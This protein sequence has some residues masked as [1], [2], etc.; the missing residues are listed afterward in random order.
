MPSALHHLHKRKRVNLKKEKYP[1]KERLKILMDKLIYLVA[2]GGPIIS[3]AQAYEIWFNKTAAGVSLIT[4]GGY[5]LGSFAWLAYGV[6]HKEKPLIL[7]SILWIFVNGL[8]VVGTFLY[9]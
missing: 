7:N 8:I 4:W 1:P 2:I 3:L 6:T 9:R 5:F